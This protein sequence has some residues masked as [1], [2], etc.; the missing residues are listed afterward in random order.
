MKLCLEITYFWK[1]QNG[2]V[3]SEYKF[4]WM[5]AGDNEKA[6]SSNPA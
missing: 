2:D 4:G 5:M 6:L 3:F 1:C